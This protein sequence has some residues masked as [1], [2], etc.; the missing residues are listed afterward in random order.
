MPT[1]TVAVKQQAKVDGIGGV[2]I[3]A[4]D[5]KALAGWYQDKLGIELAHNA[6]DGEDNYYCVF[7]HDTVFAIK[8]AKQ[9]LPAERNQFVV[10]FKVGDFAGLID[11]LKSKG[12]AV[13]RTQDYDYGRFGWIKDPEGNSI[14][15]WQSK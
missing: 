8:P 11:R 1:E 3:Y 15:F 6:C 7:P 12:V 10:N 9:T 4:N 5:M 14:E 13:D 2:F